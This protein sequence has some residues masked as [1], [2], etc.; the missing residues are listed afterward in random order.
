MM[1]QGPR[2]D[3]AAAALDAATALE[4]DG[5]LL[6]AIQL[7]T[8]A[9]NL[10]RHARIEEQLVTLRHRAFD[11][12][13]RRAPVAPV[14]IVADAEAPASL[15][16]LTPADL[17]PEA[18]RRGFA[19]NGCVLVR[20]L[21]DP[22]RVDM[23]TRGIDQA[24][25]AFDAGLA[26]APRR[27]TTPWYLPFTPHAGDYRIGGRRKWMR[28]SGGMWTVDSPH[29]LAVLIDLLDD[30]GIGTLVTEFLGERPALSAN[31]CNLRRVPTTTAGNWHQDG[32][33]L[34]K[35]VRSVNFWL[36]LSTCGTDAPG[37]D[38]LPRRL[39]DIVETGTPGA[40]FDWSVSPDVVDELAVGTPVIRPEFDPGDAL[41]FDHL[42]LHR[43]GVDPGMS[44]ERHAIETWLFAPSA[45][46]KGQIPIVF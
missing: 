17:T 36:G 1:T 8:D 45:Y 14:E 4:T 43:T 6:E 30:L 15:P 19:S 44:R 13:D 24:L 37:L 28:A 33:F 26:G 16:E 18:L 10:G 25:D 35:E 2:I 39:D 42:F 20:G 23:L 3:G 22:E 9:N 11:T 21:V 34:G 5:R 29:M 40:D 31:K 32:A 41:F 38:I 27:D 7:L 12:I 46:P